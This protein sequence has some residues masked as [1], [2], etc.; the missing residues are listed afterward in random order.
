M[1]FFHFLAGAWSFLVPSAEAQVLKDIGDRG[2][3]VEDMWDEICDI[4][5]FCEVGR[6]APALLSLK[7]SSFLL[8][9]IGGVAVLVLIYAGIRLIASRG[10]EEDQTEAKKIVLYALLGVVL[11]IVADVAVNYALSLFAIAAGGAGS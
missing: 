7:I 2:P 9:M 4:L 11:A 5:P 8:R 3:G 10:N 6:A 1:G